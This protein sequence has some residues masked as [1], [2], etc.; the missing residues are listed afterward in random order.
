MCEVIHA[1]GEAYHLNARGL[2]TAIDLRTVALTWKYFDAGGNPRSGEAYHLYVR[3]LQTAVD[4][5]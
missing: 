3:G 5:E 4:L 1:Q 2:Q